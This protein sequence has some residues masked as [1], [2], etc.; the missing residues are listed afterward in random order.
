VLAHLGLL[1]A[2][3]KD[4]DIPA[5]YE[6]QVSHMRVVRVV[7]G[8]LRTLARAFV[9]RV[10]RQHLAGGVT[11]AGL[12][13]AASLAWFAASLAVGA[14]AAW[15]PAAAAGGSDAALVLATT[16]LGLACLVVAVLLDMAGS[17][18]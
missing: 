14:W 17:P 5:V 10:W 8:L 13:G 9:R 16:V 15:H 1:R 6:D 18:R 3:L 11:P 2:R 12:L 4:V 7:P